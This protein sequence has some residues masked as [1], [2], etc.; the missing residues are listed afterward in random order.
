MTTTKHHTTTRA[1]APR[2][3][4]PGRQ[5]PATTRRPQGRRSRRPLWIAA[6]AVGIVGVLFLIFLAGR[7]GGGGTAANGQSTTYAVASPATGAD[8]PAFALPST[9]GGTVSLADLRG[10]T[11]LLF[12]QE[13]IGC[14]PCWQQIKD[15]EAAQPRLHSA[16][17]DSLVTVTTNTLDQLKQKASDEGLTTPVLADTDFAVSRQYN[18]NA[19]GMMGQS[20]DGHTFVLV[21]PDGR[22][23]WRGDYGGPPNYTMYVALDQLLTDMR[24]GLTA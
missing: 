22:I 5:K 23:R 21:G 8:A 13:G 10:K 17:I 2:D 12:F 20:A 6:T 14:E 11:V 9:T 7:S 4:R 18:A 15:L 16:G 1:A 19:Y 24:S 3:R